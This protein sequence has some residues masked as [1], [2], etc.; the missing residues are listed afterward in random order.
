MSGMLTWSEIALRLGLAFLAGGL[1]GVNRWEDGQ[2][3]GLR[4]TLLVCLAAAVAMIL[5]DVLLASR[6]K[7]PDSFAMMDVM[8]LPLG[9]L[10]GMGFIGAGAILRRGRVVDGVTTAATL[11]LVTVIGLCFGGGQSGLGTAALVLALVVLWGLKGL[12]RLAGTEQGGRLSLTL[13][14]DPG[15]EREIA[16]FLTRRRLRTTDYAIHFSPAA[17]AEVTWEVR[18]KGRR[19]GPPL[20]GILH[21]LARHPQVKNLQWTP[22]RMGQGPG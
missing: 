7:L 22:H 15:V 1:I 5:A 21:E 9:I 14:A 16:G 12:E 18:W 20:S 8:R 3:A 10:S 13:P 11:W 4:T 19:S 2:A 17:E 6:G